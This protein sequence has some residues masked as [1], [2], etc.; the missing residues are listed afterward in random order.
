MSNPEQ[1]ARQTIDQLLGAAGWHI[2]DADAANIRAAR[3]V[4]VR[5]FPLKPG[6]GFADYLLYVDGKAA[7]VIEAKRQGVTLS[8]RF[9]N[10]LDPEPRARPVFA[11]Y[12]PNQLDRDVVTPDQ[13]R[14]IVPT[15][16]DQL[17]GEIFPGRREVP[18]TLI[19]AKGRAAI[20]CPFDRKCS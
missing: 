17:F 14:T 19:F 13:I 6:H 7:G 3:G 9:T 15:F 11:A 10:G 12:D 1:E 18:K 4:V 20:E 16:R 2:C 5:E 8:G